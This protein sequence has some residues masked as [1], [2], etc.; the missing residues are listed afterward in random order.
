[1]FTDG[2]LEAQNEEGECFFE[3]RL[4]EAVADAPDG[5]LDELLDGILK[6][7]LEFSESLHF[8]DDVCLLGLELKRLPAAVGVGE[9]AFPMI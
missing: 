8:D 9:E 6:R 3:E 7:V 1:M 5:G 2:I 4:L